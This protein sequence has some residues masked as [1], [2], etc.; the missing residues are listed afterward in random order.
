MLHKYTRQKLY[1]YSD[2][3]QV[4]IILNVVIINNNDNK[5]HIQHTANTKTT[6]NII[7]S[8]L[9]FVNCKLKIITFFSKDHSGPEFTFGGQYVIYIHNI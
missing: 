6:Q 2:Y 7:F 1:F 4:N 3:I 8:L 5:K 9:F